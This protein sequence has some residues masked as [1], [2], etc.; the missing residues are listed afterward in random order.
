MEE[1]T[2]ENNQ[3]QNKTSKTL[4]KCLHLSKPAGITLIRHQLIPCTVGAKT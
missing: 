3:Q 4:S 1:K 2:H